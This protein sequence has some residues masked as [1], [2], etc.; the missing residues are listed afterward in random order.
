MNNLKGYVCVPSALKELARL[1]GVAPST[2][3]RALSG[4]SG[5]SE[6]KRRL[7]LETAEKNGV[8]DGEWVRL[9]T[10][11]GNVEIKIHLDEDIHP[12]VVHSPHGYWDG[13]E[14]GWKRVN[15]NQVT[16]NE[17]QCQVTAS[18]QTRAMLC[19]IE[20]I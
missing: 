18:V 4:K 7:I 2:V 14:D 10:S 11:V 17:P 15:I 19:R 20:K 12:S 3:S 9:E 6:Q 8:K 16:G 5:V 13:V 1:T